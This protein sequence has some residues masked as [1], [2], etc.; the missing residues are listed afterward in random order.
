MKL[1]ESV[2]RLLRA[3]NGYTDARANP[4]H[5][6]CSVFRDWLAAW[7]AWMAG[8]VALVGVLGLT[9]LLHAAAVAHL[10]FLWS[11]FVWG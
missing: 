10:D 5:Q 4:A 3:L 1:A 7:L 6:Q 9:A 8:L 2:R 11:S